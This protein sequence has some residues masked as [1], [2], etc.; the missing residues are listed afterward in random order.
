MATK[1][2][3]TKSKTKSKTTKSK[4]KPKARKPAARKPARK[5]PAKLAK[6]G[7]DKRLAVA[8]KMRDE[9]RAIVDEQTNTLVTLMRETEQLTRQASMTEIEISNQRQ[10]HI[11]LNADLVELETHHETLLA[12]GEVLDEQKDEAVA[13]RD[14]VADANKATKKQITDL[15]KATAKL[16]KEASGLTREREKLEQ[17]RQRLEEDLVRLRKIR[18]DYLAGIARF[19]ALREE[20]I[21]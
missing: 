19:R 16:E 11:R 13:A 3:S 17:K 21:A 2:K 5:A 20:M 9:A 8:A 15:G 4:S 7:D 18:D 14:E 1:R 6:V 12:E 10:V